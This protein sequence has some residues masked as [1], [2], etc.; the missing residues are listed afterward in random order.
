MRKNVKGV[1]FEDEYQRYYPYNS[2]ACHAIGFTVSG[3]VGQG[4]MEGY[5]NDELNGIN[6]REYGYLTEDMT[7]ERTTKEPVNGYNI[8]STI[9]ANAQNIVE[10]KINAFM[11]QTGAKNVSVLVMDPNSGEVLA[12]ANSNSFDL[13]EPYE[14]SAI[15]YQ[16]NSEDGDVQAQIDCLRPIQEQAEADKKAAEEEAARKA[17]EEEAARATKAAKT[18]Q[19]NSSAN[20]SYG[21]PSGSGVLTPSSGIN[22]FNGR[23]ETYYK[24][25]MAGVVSNAHAI[26]IDGDYWVRG[27][28]VK[29]YGGYVIV[30]AQMAK[31]TIIATS[32]GTGIVLDYCPAGTIDIATVW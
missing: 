2:L 19:V 23:K 17:A 28:G 1:W 20:V 6:G 32:L 30:A 26:G 11:T 18:A 8:I 10:K 5:Y 31:G 25:N 4:G 24:L 3:N 22:W 27:D 21:A 13:N 12:M 15:A 14:D 29:M 9:D 16:F 7:L